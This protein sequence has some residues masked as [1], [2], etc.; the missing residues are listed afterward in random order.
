LHD[1]VASQP[2]KLNKR[3]DVKLKVRQVPDEYI[4]NG[5]KLPEYVPMMGDPVSGPS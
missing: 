2:G 4:V 1:I 5:S 3:F